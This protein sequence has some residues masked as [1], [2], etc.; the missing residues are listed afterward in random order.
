MDANERDD[1]M[2]EGVYDLKYINKKGE[3][4]I[5]KCKKKYQF[6]NSR[7]KARIK[8]EITNSIKKLSVD[9]LNKILDFINQL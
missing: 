5:Y 7:E 3:T 6:K 9:K 4:V 2:R 1:Q 8:K